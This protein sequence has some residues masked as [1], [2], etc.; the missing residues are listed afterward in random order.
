MSHI[1]RQSTSYFSFPSASPG[2][3]L[4]QSQAQLLPAQLPLPAA[5]KQ[6]EEIYS[7]SSQKDLEELQSCPC[8]TVGQLKPNPSPS[9]FSPVLTKPQQMAGA[10]LPG[11]AANSRDSSELKIGRCWQQLMLLLTA[12]SWVG[13]LQ[14]KADGQGGTPAICYK[15]AK[16]PPWPTAQRFMTSSGQGRHSDLCGEKGSEKNPTTSRL[17][18]EKCRYG[19]KWENKESWFPPL[20][21]LQPQQ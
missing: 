8:L 2:R 16:S 11:G 14:K 3:C 10:A 6:G 1:S 20:E 19:I 17:A 13:Y 18:P 21:E 12:P 15:A 4:Q 7:C 5:Q 9:G